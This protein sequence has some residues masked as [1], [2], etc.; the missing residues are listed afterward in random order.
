MEFLREA[1][2][3]GGG[4]TIEIRYY[5]KP[6]TGLIIMECLTSFHTQFACSYYSYALSHYAVLLYSNVIAV[7]PYYVAGFYQS[8]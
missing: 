4:R 3:P 7:V 6:K 5:G 1:G 2:I 8:L